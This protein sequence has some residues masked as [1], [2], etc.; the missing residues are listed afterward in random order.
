MIMAGLTSLLPVFFL[1]LS[2]LLTNCTHISSLELKINEAGIGVRDVGVLSHLRI[3]N[4]DKT[5]TMQILFCARPNRMPETDKDSQCERKAVFCTV[6][7]SVEDSLYWDLQNILQMTWQTHS[8]FV[9]KWEGKR[10]L[11]ASRHRWKAIL[12]LIMRSD[13]WNTGWARLN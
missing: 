12:K 7:C 6:G 4:S 9:W 8:H 10:P 5:W 11:A 13:I 2:V 3:S 1:Y